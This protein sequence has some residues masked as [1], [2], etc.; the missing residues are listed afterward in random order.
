MVPVVSLAWIGVTWLAS[1]LGCA[2]PPVF[3]TISTVTVQI[4]TPGG[5][6]KRV[7]EGEQLESAKQC[8]SQTEEI[9]FEEAKTE[10]IQDIIL[11]QVKDRY[12]D[13]VFE[14]FTDENMKGNKG[15]YYRSRCMYRIIKSG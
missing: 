13:R 9:P 6:S 4:Q 11:I 12:G 5:T 8:L 10:V 2:A 14:F 15:K 3:N 1:C 7:L